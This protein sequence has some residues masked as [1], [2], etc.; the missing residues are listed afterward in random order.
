MNE[1]YEF[2]AQPKRELGFALLSNKT[3]T[4]HHPVETPE[5]QH[6]LFQAV[7]QSSSQVIIC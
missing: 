6:I 1:I 7:L 3:P 4:Q 2:T 5:K